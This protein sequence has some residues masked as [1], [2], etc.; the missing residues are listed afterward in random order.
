MFIIQP[1]TKP[2]RINMEDNHNI[3]ENGRRPQ[4][5]ENGRRPQFLDKWKTTS[6]YFLNGRQPQFIFPMEEDHTF[7]KWKTT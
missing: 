1:Y 6:I 3:F 5:F 2:T 7:F 4:T